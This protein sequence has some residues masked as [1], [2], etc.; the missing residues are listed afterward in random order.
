MKKTQAFVLSV[1]I[2]LGLLA[3]CMSPGG[4][5]REAQFENWEWYTSE[6]WGFKFKYPADWEASIHGGEYDLFIYI[7][8]GSDSYPG[9]GI[10][11][12]PVFSPT[13]T[14]ERTVRGDINFERE[15]AE[16]EGRRFELKEFLSTTLGGEPAI[17]AKTIED[18]APDI[19]KEHTRIECFHGGKRYHIGFERDLNNLK[20]SEAEWDELVKEVTNSFEFI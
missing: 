6:E 15:W 3:G 9:I 13:E 2:A 4:E 19:K 11:I 1:V 10:V 7:P 14:L 12:G 18:R 8:E 20:F 17:R 16:G 5:E